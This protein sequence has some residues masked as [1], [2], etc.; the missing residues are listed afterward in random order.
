MLDEF[1]PQKDDPRVKFIELDNNKLVMQRTDPYGFITVHFEKGQVPDS[2]K[3]HFTTWEA[4]RLAV[5]QYLHHKGRTPVEEAPAAP[6][7][8]KKK[9]A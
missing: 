4:A 8:T 1:D 7:E 9:V 3:G 6:K 5:T 2:L